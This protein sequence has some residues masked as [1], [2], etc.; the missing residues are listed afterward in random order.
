MSTP[1]TGDAALV[2]DVVDSAK[3]LIE[4]ARVEEEQLS[5]LDPV[6]PEDIW[7]A[8]EALGPDAG[9]LAV[10]TEARSRKRGR[11]PGSKNK[12]SDEFA[13]Y[14]LGFGQHPAIT[15]MQLQST[16]P[17][18]LME[19]SRR[20][21]VHSFRKD[22]TPNLVVEHMTYDAAQS[23]RVRCAEAL[24]PYIESKKPVAVDM[25]FSGVADLVIEGVTHSRDEMGEM[26]EAEFLPPDDDAEGAA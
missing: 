2:R 20:E 21:K 19:A 10:L 4:Q 24:L 5:L 3:S 6:T 8:R 9:R 16:A 13:K 26:L 23:L 7:E 1:E 25:T 22:G 14:I 12:R 17:E 11:P 18:I 15:L